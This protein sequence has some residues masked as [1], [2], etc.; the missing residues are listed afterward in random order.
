MPPV[1]GHEPISG[2]GA[3]KQGGRWNRPGQLAVYAALEFMT[4]VGEFWQE[5]ASRPGTFFALDLSVAGIL[6]VREPAVAAALG[7]AHA[8]LLCPWQKMWFFD[9]L[10][11]P[12]WRA[13][14]I[15]RTAGARGLLTPSSRVADG[16]NLVLW[17][18]S[19]QEAEIMVFDPSREMPAA[20]V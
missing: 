5:I 19:G 1:W 4:A 6:D 13:C 20:P 14:D 3:S 16:T 12:T 10:E 2:V 17:D 8:D 11:P 9:D 15:A 7:I 18:W